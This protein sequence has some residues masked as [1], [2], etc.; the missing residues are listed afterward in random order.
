M[1]KAVI[2]TKEFVFITY[3]SILSF[4]SLSLFIQDLP[5]IIHTFD[6]P[7]I[8]NGASFVKDFMYCPRNMYLSY[9]NYIV[10][11]QILRQMLN[12]S[13]YNYSR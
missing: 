6:S 4:I 12:N 8:M 13:F 10:H 5:R 7:Y 3:K 1:V 9:V 11:V 2:V